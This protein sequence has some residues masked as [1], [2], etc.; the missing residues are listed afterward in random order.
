VGK[1]YCEWKWENFWNHPLSNKNAE[2]VKDFDWLSKDA[3]G[4]DSQGGFDFSDDVSPLET[5]KFRRKDKADANIRWPQTWQTSCTRTR[6]RSRGAQA[7]ARLG[8]AV[9]QRAIWS[10]MVVMSVAKG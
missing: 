9:A 6:F 10:C 4:F 3:E 2:D 5:R 7:R 1:D 8:R